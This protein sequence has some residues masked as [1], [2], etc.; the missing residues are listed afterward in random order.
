VKLTKQVP[1][2]ALTAQDLR[3][4]HYLELQAEAKRIEGE[5]E[6]LKNELKHAGTH[7]TAHFV[8]TIEDR[9]RTNPPSLNALVEKFGEG[10]RAL[11]STSTYQLVKVTPKAGA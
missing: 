9:T 1:N 4:A 5:L 11:C 10:I 3:L 6:L 2:E 7:S 8:V